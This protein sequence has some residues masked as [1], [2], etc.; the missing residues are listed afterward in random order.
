MPERPPEF[1]RIVRANE[2]GEGT[3]EHVISA[4]D[5]ERAALAGRFGLRRLDRLEAS[6]RISPEA[7][8]YRID[9]TVTADLVQAC[10]ATD[11]DVPAHLDAPFVIRF[12]RDLE[13][14]ESEE[15][16]IELRDEDCDLLPLEDERI[17]L[18]E[19]AAQTLALNLDPYP[20][21]AGADEVLR[22]LGVL[23]EDEAGSLAA[24]FRDVLS[25]KGGGKR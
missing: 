24:A 13:T 1:S 6:A 8:G 20:R 4:T 23:R 19:A 9:G 22:A 5:Q 12:V 15:D 11:E 16:E 2:I 10:V 7:N 25:G 21:A 18:G 14:A 17:D 3:R